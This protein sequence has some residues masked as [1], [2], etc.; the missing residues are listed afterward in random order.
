MNWEEIEKDMGAYQSALDAQSAAGADRS[1]AEGRARR[2]AIRTWRNA[3]PEARGR[4]RGGR[5]ARGGAPGSCGGARGCPAGAR[6]GRCQPRR[7]R[8]QP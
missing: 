1:V 2:T 7:S 6:R 8:G 3:N 5:A 4:A